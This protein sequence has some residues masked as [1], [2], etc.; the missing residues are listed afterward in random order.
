MV[1]LRADPRHV[2]LGVRRHLG[3]VDVVLAAALATAGL[4]A[5]GHLHYRGSVALAVVSCLCCTGA[6]ALRRVAPQVAMV[7]VVT[8]V[9]VYQSVTQDPQGAFVSAALVLVGYIFGRSLLRNGRY[10]QDALI[11]AYTLAVLEVVPHI[12]Q[13]SKP[14]GIAGT[15][16]TTVVLPTGV[17]AMLERRDQVT[18]Q[19]SAALGRL[20]DEK[21]IQTERAAAEER[22]RVAREL[23]DV[24]AHHLSV[25]T[26]QSA[27]ARTVADR[28]DAAISAL[29]AVTESGREALA[30]LRRITGVLRRRDDQWAAY[31]PRLDQLDL[32]IARTR[33]AGVVTRLQI[34]GDLRVVPPAI[35][36]AAYRIIQEALTNVV[37]HAATTSASVEV[38]VSGEALGLLVTN[39][40]AD[41]TGLRPR[42]PTT[43]Q[44]LVGMRERV[45]LYGGQLETG[46][47]SSGGYHVR[48]AIPLRNPVAVAPA[49]ASAATTRTP[50]YRLRWVALRRH[51]D[52][53]LAG[54]WLVVLELEA[55]TSGHRHG[56]LA[57]NM[58]VVGVMAVIG[59][60][61]RR[62]PL[63]FLGT[64]GGLA[65]LLDGGLD[66]LQSATIT[67]T[68][69]LLVPLYTVAVWENRTRAAV[70]LLVWEAAVI[71]AGFTTHAPVAGIAGAAVMAGIVW[72]AGRIWRN[73]RQL[74]SELAGT[75]S[76][77]ETE[78]SEREQLAVA[79]QRAV[80]AQDL[81]R[82]VARHVV[83]MIVHAQAA[84]SHRSP[85]AI[86]S[87]AG[88]IE[89]TGRQA[90]ARMRDI[91][92]VLRVHGISADLS[93]RP[94]PAADSD[95][96]R[97]V[98]ESGLLTLGR[99]TG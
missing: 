3:L 24:V 85:E 82:L 77:L 18:R 41:G 31:P 93:P 62:W 80:I 99:E 38:S 21:R 67:G 40:G 51:T 15:W 75:I 5:L 13:Q 53:L 84:Q 65:L 42:L 17:G 91:L 88:V 58:V 87:A 9:A 97:A 64:V 76:R 16:L 4:T 32:L 74:Q 79:N 94:G 66:T 28:P 56:S 48:A 98:R 30:D 92:G 70:G 39:D 33:T 46:R 96:D 55:R 29:R 71:P 89:D 26:I 60:W 78:G 43:G 10:I 57:L 27:A 25:M 34:V 54:A 83:D 35:D 69:I 45:D 86:R 20:R 22:N 50:P 37:K 61:R 95:T 90:L 7:L 44:G 52:V 72:V 12:S 14:A 63:L 81:D 68:Y 6:V 19:L 2:L 49:A 47:T 1:L 23:H 73:Y 8:S 59:L 36:L 11:L